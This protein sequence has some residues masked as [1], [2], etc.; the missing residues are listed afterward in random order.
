MERLGWICCVKWVLAID[1]ILV[2]KKRAVKGFQMKR[3]VLETERGGRE[4]R[5][6][7]HVV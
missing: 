1:G 5:R 3:R 2:L 6:A 7:D 4:G